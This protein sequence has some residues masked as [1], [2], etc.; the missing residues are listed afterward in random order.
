[1]GVSGQNRIQKNDSRTAEV[2][3]QVKRQS[4]IMRS[5]QINEKKVL[6]DESWSN[7]L[8]RRKIQ[9]DGNE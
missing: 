8:I 1:M 2:A 5:E 3:N 9:Q 4:A 7:H 6:W